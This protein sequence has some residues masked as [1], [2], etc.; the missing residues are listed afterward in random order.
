MIS[1]PDRTTW[2]NFFKQTLVKDC[3]LKIYDSNNNL[4]LTKENISKFTLKHRNA[5]VLYQVPCLEASFEVVDWKSLNSNTKLLLS[6]AD[7]QLRIRFVVEG[8]ETTSYIAIRIERTV[9][10][11]KETSASITL[12]SNVSLS[13]IEDTLVQRWINGYKTVTNYQS[14]PT[15]L[16]AGEILQVK[17]IRQQQG[18]RITLDDLTYGTP[19]VQLHTT[20]DTTFDIANIY[21]YSYSFD[22]QDFTNVVLYGVK[23]GTGSQ[24]LP[25][26]TV[27]TY[28]TSFVTMFSIGELKAVS[29]LVVTAVSVKNSGSPTGYY[30][31]IIYN[32]KITLQITDVHTSMGLSIDGYLAE[33]EQPDDQTI[34]YIQTYA[35]ESGDVGL[36]NAQNYCRSYYSNNKTI[37]CQCRVD[38]TI[39]PLDVVEANLEEGTMRFFVEEVSITFNGGFSGSIKGRI[40]DTVLSIS[41]SGQQTSFTKNDNFAF[42]GTVTA[43]TS[44]GNTI[45]VTSSCTFSGYD[46]D[47]I[48][49]QTVTVT[50]TQGDITVTTTYQITINPLY[51][52]E[53]IIEETSYLDPFYIEI[54]NPNDEECELY[55]SCS[56]GTITKMMDANETLTLNYSNTPELQESANAKEMG[57]LQDA[58]VCHLEG[59]HTDTNNVTIWSAD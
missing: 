53:P 37:D 31:C 49:T 20:V 32:N 17:N 54:T 34:P 38:P 7:T 40:I 30:H 15:G 48:G 11:R 50:Y 59:D 22:S 13:K 45:D 24:Q 39:E 21:D 36:T 25:L 10:D 26:K 29:P 52:A 2:Q 3:D 9:I 4:L 56:I 27:T 28:S 44:Y 46:M 47:T 41:A 42:G 6:N 55:I 8:V 19:E 35:F 57:G 18:Y 1:V 43:T 51:D 5:Y 16:S 33:L 12:S 58:V 23:S 14:L